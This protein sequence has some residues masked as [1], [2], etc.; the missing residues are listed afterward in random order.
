M[1]GLFFVAI[2]AIA[3]WG[4]VR[5]SDPL[6]T[7]VAAAAAILGGIL[8]FDLVAWPLQALLVLGLILLK[9]RWLWEVWGQRDP[10]ETGP[11]Y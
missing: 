9:V 2:T 10:E 1:V 8:C 3:V 6:L 7:L 11:S 5:V 4:A